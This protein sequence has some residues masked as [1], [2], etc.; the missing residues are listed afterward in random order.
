MPSKTDRVC[1]L[2]VSAKESGYWLHTL[3]FYNLGN[4]LDHTTLSVL[5]GLRIGASIVQ[6][7]RCHCGGSVD[8][9]GHHGHKAL[10]ASLAIA[11]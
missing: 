3:P 8:I 11:P 6:P 9:Y 4:I 7:Q 1:L 10:V 5:S 2:A